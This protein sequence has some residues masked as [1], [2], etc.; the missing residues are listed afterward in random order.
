MSLYVW[1]LYHVKWESKLGDQWHPY[2]WGFNNQERA[3]SLRENLLLDL[4]N[5]NIEIHE[6][7]LFNPLDLHP[8]PKP[9]QI[10]SSE[11]RRESFFRYGLMKSKSRYTAD[12]FAQWCA[13]QDLLRESRTT[14]RNLW[15]YYNRSKRGTATSKKRRLLNSL[16]EDIDLSEIGLRNK[17]AV[18]H[19]RSQDYLDICETDHEKKI[20]SLVASGMSNKEVVYELGLR[21][22]E[23]EEFFEKIRKRCLSTGYRFNP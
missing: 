20:M 7:D 15:A 16:K 22:M 6:E 23:L 18:N 17:E 19:S 8:T 12:D 5:R 9:V 1:K 14:L 3:K 13:L 21:P 4:N 2:R 11:Y 10:V